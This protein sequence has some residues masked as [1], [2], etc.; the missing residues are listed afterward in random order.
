M[1]IMAGVFLSFLMIGMALPVLPLH[2]HDVLGFGPFVVGLVAGCQFLASLVSRLWAGRLTDTRGPKRAMALG[3][4][5][6]ALGGVCYLAS[7]LALS[8]PVIS[9][10]ILLVGRTLLGGAE[11]LVVTSGM[12]WGLGLVASNRSAKVIAWV[13]MSMFAALAL[14]APLGSAIYTHFAFLGI[15]LTSTAIPL[16]ALAIISPLRPL[17]PLH[18]AKG[19]ISAVFSAVLLPGLGFALSGITFGTV[20]A[21]L[22]LYFAIQHWANGALAFTLFAS[23]LIGARIFGGHLPDRFGGARVAL[24]CLFG[25]AAGLAVIAAASSSLVAMVGAVIAGAGFSL[26]FP[27]LGLEAVRRAPEGNRGLA[28]GAYNAFLDLTLG[29]GS[30][31]LGLLASHAGLGAVFTASAIAALLAV[32]IARQKRQR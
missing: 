10:A 11:S 20:T 19:R 8:M 26:V 17:I 18:V 9:V 23:A 24:V 14:G 28:M 27:S 31:L 7:L 29:L 16:V 2:V 3:L 32:P 21:F 12:L 25:Q 22:T 15:A 13:G 1:P 5:T 30:P 6:G 4:I